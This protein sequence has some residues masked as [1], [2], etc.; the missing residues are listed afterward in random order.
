[1]SLLIHLSADSKI[2]LKIET[3]HEKLVNSHLVQPGTQH[4][5]TFVSA[6]MAFAHVSWLEPTY[7]SVQLISQ[8]HLK[9]NVLIPSKP[10]LGSAIAVSELVQFTVSFR[11]V[12]LGHK[13]SNC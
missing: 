1:M 7:I 6:M 12:R 3:S 5:F 9:E 13:T 8:Q 11:A 2:I 10:E 4:H